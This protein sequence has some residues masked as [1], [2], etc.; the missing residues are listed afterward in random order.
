MNEL[1]RRRGMFG[2]A[3][4][5]CVA[6][7][8]VILGTTVAVGCKG[9]GG[10]FAGRKNSDNAARSNGPALGSPAKYSAG[11]NETPALKSPENVASF[12]PQ[13][14]AASARQTNPQ[15]SCPVDGK[16]LGVEGAPATVTLKGEPV[17]VCCPAC[18]KKAQKDPD[19]YLAK[20]HR[21]TAARN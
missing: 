14:S 10:G 3:R 20:V 1:G 15:V 18:A 2:F 19:K 17:F 12:T 6:A 16:S 11:R 21:E 4:L 13:S 7:A 5:R 9:G 8:V